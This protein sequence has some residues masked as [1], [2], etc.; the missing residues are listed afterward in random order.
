[1]KPFKS[2]SKRKRLINGKRAANQH[3]GYFHCMEMLRMPLWCVC[4]FFI[5]TVND[6]TLKC[7]C[8]FGFRCTVAPHSSRTCTSWKKTSAWV[9][10]PYASA[11][12][13]ESQPWSSQSRLYTLDHVS[14]PCYQLRICL[15]L[16]TRGR[17]IPVN[18]ICSLYHMPR[19]KKYEFTFKNFMHAVDHI[20]LLINLHKVVL[21]ELGLFWTKPCHTD[22]TGYYFLAGYIFGW[23]TQSFILTVHTLRCFANQNY[24]TLRQL[25][26]NHHFII[27]SVIN[28]RLF[29]DRLRYSSNTNGTEPLNSHFIEHW[30]LP[31]LRCA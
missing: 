12:S 16:L 8:V 14:Q 10:T 26:G 4:L 31:F 25:T 3:V 1:M 30:Q 2:N 23:W 13:T 18:A 7:L 27:N 29:S 5:L 17:T 24:W 20:F 9:H 15:S 22:N 6:N 28:L 21:Q 11:A 19:Y